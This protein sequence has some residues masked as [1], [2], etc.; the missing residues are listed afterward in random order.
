MVLCGFASCCPI[1]LFIFFRFSL[2]CV[3]SNESC[4]M[5]QWLM[6]RSCMVPGRGHHFLGW[7]LRSVYLDSR[8]LVR[9][10]LVVS[11]R[12]F[13]CVF[14]PWIGLSLP[15]LCLFLLCSLGLFLCC[16]CFFFVAVRLVLV[17]FFVVLCAVSP[18]LIYSGILP[19]GFLFADLISLISFVLIHLCVFILFSS[20]YYMVDL[21]VEVIG[22]SLVV[23]WYL[24]HFCVY[25]WFF[26]DVL[27]L[28]S[29][30]LFES[31][32]Y[33]F[34]NLLLQYVVVDAI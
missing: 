27:H 17:S 7:Q 11:R 34:D 23:G 6:W 18:F 21:C 25:F 22:G 32:V 33:S 14:I 1:C 9:L 29:H 20:C 28:R 31:F 24:L 19:V 30:C 15:F 2:F 3:L 26:Y 12:F 13:F 10:F 5:C 4:L 8:L 16:R